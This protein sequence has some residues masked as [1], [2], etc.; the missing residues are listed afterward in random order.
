MRDGDGQMVYLMWFEVY[1]VLFQRFSHCVAGARGTVA[2]GLVPLCVEKLV[3]EES[4]ELKVHHPLL[5][6]LQLLLLFQVMT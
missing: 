2:A 4:L 6:T 5:P 1:L 3:E